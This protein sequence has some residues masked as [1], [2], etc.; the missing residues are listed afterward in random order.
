MINN[1]FII[2]KAGIC[3]YS[4]N[5]QKVTGIDGQMLSGFLSALSAFAQEA[6]QTRLQSIEIHNGQ[7]L[8]FYVDP[9]HKLTFCAIADVRDNSKFLEKILRQ[10]G[11]RFVLKF[12][13]VFEKDLQNQINLFNSFDG[14]L[15][16]ITKNITK[17]RNPRTL[18]LG[19]IIGLICL[20]GLFIPSLYLIYLANEGVD[21]NLIFSL[22][23][24]YLSAVLAISS[25]ISGYIAGSP[26]RGLLTGGL[27]F[28]I[29]NITLAIIAYDVF[30]STVNIALSF[31]ILMA[32]LAAGYAGGLLCDRHKLY[33]L[34]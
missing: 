22:F 12:W 19:L 20:I 9:M 8:V 1:L 7:K 3:L 30:T 27:F 17:A 32:C 16:P 2:D 33:P 21:N 25:F 11:D 34:K 24:L 18:I 31:F 23:L 6:F 26:R 15:V 4:Y 10:M 5:F 29:I 14:D 13:E 28:L